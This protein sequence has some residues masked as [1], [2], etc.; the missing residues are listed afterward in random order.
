MFSADRPTDE[1]DSANSCVLNFVKVPTNQGNKV[2]AERKHNSIHYLI[3]YVSAITW[4]ADP[5][6]GRYD[7]VLCRQT[8]TGHNT[9]RGT[10]P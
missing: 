8:S 5:A 9:N 6:S 1:H 7:I 3:K 4:R 2:P 10:K